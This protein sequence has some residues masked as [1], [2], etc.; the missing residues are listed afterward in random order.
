MIIPP[1]SNF[2]LIVNTFSLMAQW[3]HGSEG[4]FKSSLNDSVQEA[5]QGKDQET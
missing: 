4:H 5:S 1:S 2:S 3:S